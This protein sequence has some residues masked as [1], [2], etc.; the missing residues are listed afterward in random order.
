VTASPAAS[1]APSG[2]P[3]RT[4]RR[5]RPGER[6]SALVEFLTVGLLLMVP[7]VYLV[8]ALARI[9]AASFAVDGSAREAARALVTATTEEEGRRRA[10]E[11]VRL[12]LL[13]QG[14]DV[15]VEDALAIE[16]S[17]RPCLLPGARVVARVQVQVVLPGVPALLDRVIPARVTVRAQQVLAVDAFRPPPP[18]GATP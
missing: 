11:A 18:A 13:D 9:E 16:C 3:A 17:G 4:A 14:F 8:L 2:S 10:A 12:G 1:I 7:L 15:P 5:A 6:G